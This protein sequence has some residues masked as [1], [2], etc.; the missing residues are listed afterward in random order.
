MK[1]SSFLRSGMLAF[2]L[3][4]GLPLAASAGPIGLG[5][6]PAAPRAATNIIPVASQLCEIR[7]DCRRYG[8][9]DGWRG[10]NWR[11]NNWRGDRWRDDRRWRHRPHRRNWGGTGIYLNF[12]I[13]AYRYDEPRYYQPRYV[14]P[15]RV[16]RGG[17]SSVHVRWCYNRYRSYRAWDNTF[18]PYNGPR[19]QCWSPY[20]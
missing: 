19:Q 6:L 3:V 9:R 15:R 7:G 8:R 14:Q 10:D 17:L 5:Q 16:Y 20:S 13:P 12:G 4:A 1:L 18:Q 2:G 11:H